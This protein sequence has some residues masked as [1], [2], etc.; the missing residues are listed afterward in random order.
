ML[1]SYQL[2]WGV[3]Q[4]VAF[5]KDKD[6]PVI[7]RTRQLM[8]EIG[9]AKDDRLAP[10]AL[11]DI[12]L[13]DPYLA[14]KLLRRA[15]GHRSQKLGQETTTAL[16]AVLQAGVD[17]MVSTVSQ[18]DVCSDTDEGL[19]ACEARVVIAAH[20]ARRWGSLRADV[21]AEEL[22]MAALLSETG[23]LILWHF[24]PELPQRSLDELRSGRA[25]RTLQAQQ[26]A[27]GFPFKML[28]L[29]LTHAWELPNLITQLIK[30]SDNPRANIT[31]LAMDTA[32]H[33]TAHPEN[34]AI[35]ADIVNIKALMPGV[36]HR[37]LI[38]P[39]PISAE[40]KEA[41]LQM[42]DEDNV[43]MEPT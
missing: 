36:S 3:E 6:I 30:G 14:L 13:S 4:W 11:A 5:L 1:T 12:V 8:L 21:S 33:I 26:Q 25:L 19:T 40:Y 23:E 35:P 22:A 34:P 20:I 15:E 39:L 42:I 10:K 29:A 38:A 28:T 41:V 37:N 18:S 31:R 9:E 27:A 43:S 32:R 2:R 24:A 16:A 17:G 7:S